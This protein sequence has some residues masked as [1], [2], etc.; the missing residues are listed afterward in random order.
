MPGQRGGPGEPTSTK[1]CGSPDPSQPRAQ[2]RPA[3]A[4]LPLTALSFSFCTNSVP[5]TPVTFRIW[6]SWSRSWQQVKA[7][8][9]ALGAGLK[10]PS[11]P[12]LYQA[13]P[14]AWTI[15]APG[16]R[17]PLLQEGR[18][19]FWAQVSGRLLA[20]HAGLKVPPH[21]CSCM[22]HLPSLTPPIPLS[23]SPLPL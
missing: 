5:G 17:L 4:P 10:P 19:Y 22:G 9:H 11:P 18:F 12:R 1:A 2:P 3:W 16:A 8:P 21:K 20:R 14:K 23:S 7:Q 6:V 15:Q 13:H